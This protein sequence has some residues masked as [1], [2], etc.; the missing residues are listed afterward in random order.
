MTEEISGRKVFSGRASL[1]PFIRDIEKDGGALVD[2]TENTTTADEHHSVSVAGAG[3]PSTA[4]R[5][6]AFIKPKLVKVNIK[7]ASDTA[8]KDEV[9]LNA[10]MPLMTET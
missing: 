10:K 8:C 7:S 3:V 2:L 9:W 5:K 4:V 6:S 1:T